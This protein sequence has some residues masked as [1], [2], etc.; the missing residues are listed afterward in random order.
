LP[1]GSRQQS[2]SG[3]PYQ[4]DVDYEE[5]GLIVELDGRAGHDGVGQFRD[6]DRD[7]RHMLVNART[8]RYGSY[9]LVARP[10]SVAFQVY[11]ALVR[12]GYL[13]AFVRCRRCMAATEADL[14]FA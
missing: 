2:R 6:M 3:L 5:Y 12:Q 1:K 7:N 9:D 11:S 13:E 14:L 8:L 4:T 10:C